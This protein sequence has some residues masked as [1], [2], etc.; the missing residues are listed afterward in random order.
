[1]N[2]NSLIVCTL[3]L[4]LP[5]I[6][7]GSIPEVL[8][9]QAPTIIHVEQ[10]RQHPDGFDLLL[11]FESPSFESVENH[12]GL[13]VPTFSGAG[14]HLESGQ[15]VTPQAGRLFRLPPT[16]SASVEIISA[17]YTTISDVQ[18]AHCRNELDEE[19]ITFGPGANLQDAWYPGPVAEVG[20][21]ALFHDFRV[22]N[23]LTHPVQVN[24]ARN[25]MRVYNRMEI[26]IRFDGQDNRNSL[27]QQPSK[28]SATFLPLYRDFLD[29]D[30][31]ELDEYLY[32]QGNVVVVAQNDDNLMETLQPWIEW[33]RQKG[34]KLEFLT[35][36]DVAGWTYTN[37]INELQS[38]YNL[39]DEKFD[40]VV[41]VGDDQGAFP[42]PASTGAIYGAGDLHYGRLAG[43]DYLVDAAVGRIT[44]EDISQVAAATS[45]IIGY[46]SDPFM[47]DTDWFQHA[48]LYKSD[49]THSGTSKVLTLRYWLHLLRQVGYTQVDTSWE[50]DNIFMTGLLEDG[51]SVFSHRGYLGYGLQANHISVLE[52]DYK[53]PM[54]VDLTCMT[55]NWS[56]GTG[57][58]EVWFRAGTVDVPTGA[59]GAIGMATT[60]NRPDMNNPISGGAA[61]ALLGYRIP[62]IGMTWLGAQVNLWQNYDDVQTATSRQNQAWCNLMGDPTTWAWTAVPQELTIS[63]DQTMYVGDNTVTVSVSDENGEPVS[64]AWVTYYK[65]DDYE[66]IVETKLSQS[67]G[68]VV[69]YTPNR[70]TGTGVV[71]ASKQ[72]YVPVQQQIAISTPT[73]RIGY[74][75]MAIVDNGQGETVGNGDGVA[76]A[77]E[78][79]GIRLALKNF[80][81]IAQSSIVVSGASDD[82]MI[83]AVSGAISR[84]SL[85]PGQQAW[86]NDIIIVQLAPNIQD[87]WL[88]HLDLLFSTDQGDYEDECE[89]L[90]RA[91]KFEIH[92][93]TTQNMRPGQAG[94]VIAY[95]QNIGGADAGNAHATL[96]SSS[97]FVITNGASVPV[98]DIG[99]DGWACATFDVSLSPVAAHGIEVDA[100]I[101]IVD[102][103]THTSTALFTL[104]IGERESWDPVGPDGY[105]YLAIENCDSV[106]ENLAV[107]FNWLEINPFA[108][109]P[110]YAGTIL[111]L[112]DLAENDDDAVSLPLPFPVS[113]YGEVFDT[114]TVTANG[115]VAL[116]NQADLSLA[117]N[118]SIPSPLGPNN[119][120]APY[121]DEFHTTGDA[122]VC[123]YHHE[124][125]GLFIVEFYHMQH[126]NNSTCTFEIL[127]Q[128]VEMY[129]TPSMDNNIIFQYGECTHTANSGIQYD[130]PYW[131]TGIENGDQTDGLQLAFWNTL[132]PG[133]TS[134]EEGRAILFTTQVFY[135]MSRV[136]GRVYEAHTGEPVAGAVISCYDG[137]ISTTSDIEGEYILDQVVPGEVTFSVETDC[138]TDLESM[139]VY[140]PVMDTVRLDFEML[141]PDFQ[142]SNTMIRDTLDVREDA[143]HDIVLANEGEGELVFN[144]ALDWPG[145][146]A[147]LSSGGTRNTSESG[148]LD[149]LWEELYSFELLTSENRYRGLTFDGWHFWIAG[150]NNYDINGPNLLYCYSANGNHIGTFEQPVP[151]GER[152]AEGFYELAWDGRYLYGADAG[153]LYQMLPEGNTVR[154]VNSFEIEVNPSHVMV[155][156]PR[157]EWY[158]IGGGNNPLIAVNREGTI[159][160]E[161]ELEV[162][163]RGAAWRSHDPDGYYMYLLVQPFSESEAT[164]IKMNP[165]NGDTIPLATLTDLGQGDWDVKGALFTTFW[166]NSNA[167]LGTVVSSESGNYVVLFDAGIFTDWV[168]V[169]SS[170][171]RLS[172]GETTT[173]GFQL[174]NEELLPGSYSVLAQFEH[175]ACTENPDAVSITLVVPGVD[176]EEP[177]AMPLDWAFDGAWPNPFNSSVQVGFSL[178]QA[179]PVRIAIYNI[180]GQKVA[181][182][183]NERMAAGKHLIPFHGEQ[184]ASGVYFLQLDAGP[185]QETRK[186][187]LLR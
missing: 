144:I 19:D 3:L 157:Q 123:T 89:I 25:E 57:T 63:C 162:Y 11:S 116:G 51:V 132:S 150:S 111:D 143:T 102:E 139:I 1:M 113:Y 77:G 42:V 134:I 55:G 108:D 65:V 163:V 110:V 183:A 124:Q 176:A 87:E 4:V 119:M 9:Q 168:V 128:D 118:W 36:D 10:C 137:F 22:A 169:S 166:N 16:G 88:V 30:D 35:D 24:P 8:S 49:D 95:I 140:V 45:K 97:N 86:D 165:D 148:E 37:I 54:V 127:F 91:P 172:P 18:I 23:L 178:K 138:Y 66:E 170:N 156:D 13:V 177:P 185:L 142:I 81:Q 125:N 28:I 29:W 164:I 39:A 131:T 135:M 145:N 129:P 74:A 59:I 43:D 7:L 52:N 173:I 105:G 2:R 155:V 76:Q 154:R 101:V 146:D 100:S 82:P 186:L 130:N 99:I 15:P 184:L 78:T 158:W 85:I 126:Y 120:I 67:D 21:P 121:W 70:F 12:P 60:S 133:M 58:N 182:L 136:Y 47:D 159:V 48:A 73:G 94:S 72:H 5:C 151:E 56:Q 153:V 31:S 6:C 50:Q 175:N 181:D 117:R 84:E 20:S 32:Y 64:G 174:I 180:L 114:I 68:T 71:T 90:V 41:V 122:V 53:L 69:L 98:G 106:H 27:P 17:E 179:V 160:S 62:E 80:G 93:V 171:G 107:E 26:A 104:P 152:T 96:I 115:Y 61:Q 161:I 34:W 38:R 79:I 187:I 112:E 109:D 83:Q 40:F 75:D 14:L 141:A 46:E 92:S 44:V 167:A 147:K 103:N 33:K 149:E